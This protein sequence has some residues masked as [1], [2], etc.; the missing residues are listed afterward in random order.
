MRCSSG[1]GGLSVADGI[2]ALDVPVSTALYCEERKKRGERT[3]ISTRENFA[4]R[5]QPVYPTKNRL[6]RAPPPPPRSAYIRP[7]RLNYEI[8]ALRINA[9]R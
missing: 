6:A 3:S 8:R 1:D 9:D 5:P 7:F 2:F 4:H